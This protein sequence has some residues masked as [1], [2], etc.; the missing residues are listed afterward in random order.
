MNALG[1]YRE[2][3]DRGDGEASGRTRHNLPCS[4]D[5]SDSNMPSGA[6]ESR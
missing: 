1:L 4:G 2:S 3:L 6:D 5:F